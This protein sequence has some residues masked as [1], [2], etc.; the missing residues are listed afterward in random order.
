MQ[1]T[2]PFDTE[3]EMRKFESG[4]PTGFSTH[5][6]PKTPQQKAVLALQKLRR[7]GLPTLHDMA[8]ATKTLLS[9]TDPTPPSK[10]EIRWAYSVVNYYKRS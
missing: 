10:D 3:S 1:L 6:Q 5:T 9:I 2:V 7:G 4:V 8:L